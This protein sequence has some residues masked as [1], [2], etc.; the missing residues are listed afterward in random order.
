MKLFFDLK[1][2]GLIVMQIMDC[3]LMRDL[4]ADH[5][6]SPLFFLTKASTSH[7]HRCAFTAQMS[8]SPFSLR[9]IP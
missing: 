2:T 5:S 4:F 6:T 7:I 8:T 1:R 3:P 9:S